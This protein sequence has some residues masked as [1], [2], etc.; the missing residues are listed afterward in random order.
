[1]KEAAQFATAF[2]RIGR[3]VLAE[4]EGIP[5]NILYWPMPVP[6]GCSLFTLATQLVEESTFWV[7]VIV[8][9]QNISD[10][11]Q[12]EKPSIGKFSDL[13]VCYNQW[14]TVIHEVLDELPDE[15]MSVFV[16]L[17]PSYRNIFDGGITTVRDCLL[18]TL[19]QSALQLGRIKFMCQMLTDGERIFQEVIEQDDE[20]E[21]TSGGDQRNSFLHSN[22]YPL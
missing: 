10:R 14:M 17:P 1:M 5:G 20:W 3:E 6:Q 19:G 21:T 13:I 22:P 8:G 15:I 11:E 18:H 4:L 16:V 9:G 7:M 12:L 2:D